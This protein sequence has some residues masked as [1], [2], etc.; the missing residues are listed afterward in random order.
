MFFIPFVFS[1]LNGA[2]AVPAIAAPDAESKVVK[3][4]LLQIYKSQSATRSGSTAYGTSL[5]Q[6]GM[7][8]SNHC[9]G[10]SL[11][12]SSVQ[13]KSFTITGELGKQKWSVDENK[14]LLDLSR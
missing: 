2:W 6:I 7:S 8:N 9:A 5:E 14:N 12:F 4:C 1:F 13:E 10:I 11:D 3:A